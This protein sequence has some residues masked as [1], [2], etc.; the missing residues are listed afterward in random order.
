MDEPLLLGLWRTIVPVPKQIW[1]GQVR[2]QTTGAGPTFMTRDHHRVRD[3]AVLD[4]PRTAHPLP[5]DHFSQR[6]ALP[7]E[8]VTA[9]LDDLEAGMT[10]LYRGDGVAVTWAYPITVDPTPH[11]VT[12][13]TGEQ[14]HAA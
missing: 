10:F 12:F 11:R 6:L 4:L 8:Q 9:L 2:R 1:Q 7:V 14:I 3:L 5:P 13:S